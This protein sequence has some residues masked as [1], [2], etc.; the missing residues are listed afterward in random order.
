MNE[1]R[2]WVYEPRQSKIGS[3][4]EIVGECKYYKIKTEIVHRMQ[5]LWSNTE[6]YHKDDAFLSEMLVGILS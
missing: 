2:S 4:K 5:T 1:C 3:C 6:L